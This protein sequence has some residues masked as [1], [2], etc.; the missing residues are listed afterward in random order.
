MAEEARSAG[1]G[2]GGENR[3]ALERS[4]YGAVVGLVV[5]GLMFG[6]ALLGGGAFQALELFFYRTFFPIPTSGPAHSPHVVVVTKDENANDFVQLRYRRPPN[7]WPRQAHADLLRRLTDLGAKVVGFDFV[8][9]GPDAAATDAALA[10]SLRGHG[11]SVLG[12]YK[13]VRMLRRGGFAGGGG[14]FHSEITYLYPYGPFQRASAA[15]G[16]LNIAMGED[17]R[18]REWIPLNY[19]R[20]RDPAF[21]AV[22]PPSVATETEEGEEGE[23]EEPEDRGYVD[24][25]RDLIPAWDL[26]L[27]LLYRDFDLEKLY[28]EGRWVDRA[29]KERTCERYRRGD[30]A[31]GLD[32]VQGERHLHVPLNSEG[33][34]L[35][36]YRKPRSFQTFSVANLL[37]PE[38]FVAPRTAGELPR[39]NLLRQRGGIP[40]RGGS[41]FAFSRPG[42]AGPISACAASM[43]GDGGSPGWTSCS[44]PSPRASGCGP[45]PTRAVP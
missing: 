25:D 31:A 2:A 41:P 22:P 38:E 37:D 36:P 32:F 9:Q 43:P 42:R 21:G 26:L 19:D 7:R 13:N 8:F 14:D 4:R 6:Y 24:G 33:R 35:I 12:M 18:V 5:L 20:D 27:L 10:A 28:H 29:W 1:R 34:C 23:E 40:P 15:C 44:R 11:R 16:L 17:R 3:P 39:G 30:F 45:V